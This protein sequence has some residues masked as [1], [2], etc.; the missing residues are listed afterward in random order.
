MPPW[1]FLGEKEETT[2]GQWLSSDKAKFFQNCCSSKTK[3][4]GIPTTL[5]EKEK[6]KIEQC[7]KVFEQ[8]PVHEQ[9]ETTEQDI[10]CEMPNF[11]LGF[12]FLSEHV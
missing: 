6:G 7:I 11:K 5:T 10:K 2:I 1:N 4:H 9:E 3:E 12:D 8:V